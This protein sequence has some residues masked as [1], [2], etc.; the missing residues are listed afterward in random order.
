MSGLELTEVVPV[1]ATNRR[2]L[3]AAADRPLSV[4][5]IC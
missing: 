2:G 3:T 5:L 1:P 4:A